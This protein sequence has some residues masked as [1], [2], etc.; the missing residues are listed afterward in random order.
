MPLQKASEDMKYLL[1]RGYSRNASLNLTV[2]RYHLDMGERNYLRRYV[3]SENEI[4]V[5]KSKLIPVREI[6]GEKVVVDGFNVLITVEAVLKNRDLVEGMDCILRDTSRVFS[7]YRFGSE[8]KTALGKLMDLFMEY[9]PEEVFFIFDSQISRS[10]ELSSYVRKK[11]GES[12]IPGDARTAKSADGEIIE[13]NHITASSD[14]HI[15]ESVD[16]IIDLPMEIKHYVF[17]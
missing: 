6:N 5:H 17:M 15:I 12:G 2:N 8:T 3:F 11:M 4:R 1:D 10:G 13:L 14:S 16:R 7:S 9:G